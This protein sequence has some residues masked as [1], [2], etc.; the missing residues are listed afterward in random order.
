MEQAA[1]VSLRGAALQVGGVVLDREQIRMLHLDMKAV[2]A[3]AMR[4]ASLAR[5][6]AGW[7]GSSSSL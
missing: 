2:E 4:S 1:P 3:A 7:A 5:Q 6:D